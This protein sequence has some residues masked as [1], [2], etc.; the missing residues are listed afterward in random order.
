[1]PRHLLERVEVLLGQLKVVNSK[2][3]ELSKS[4]T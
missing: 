1:V 3:S 4:A 2:L